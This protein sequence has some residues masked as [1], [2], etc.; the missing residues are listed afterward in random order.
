MHS[1]SKLKELQIIK[2]YLVSADDQPLHH[3]TDSGV[4][5]VIN[6]CNQ[7]KSIHFNILKIHNVFPMRN[8]S[9]SGALLRGRI[10][11]V[12]EEKL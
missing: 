7:I 2:M 8:N 4:C 5:D 12:Q 11:L 3:I 6:Y 10:K 9:S 1:L